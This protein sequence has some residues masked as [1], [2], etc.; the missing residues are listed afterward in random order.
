MTTQRI[1]WAATLLIAL[2]Q[3]W[4]S[5]FSMDSDGIA[6]LEVARTLE[7]NAY[8]SPLFSW[9]LVPIVRWVPLAWSA[10]AVHA[11]QA[12]FAISAV[13]LADKLWRQ[14]A[15]ETADNRGW[16]LTRW[17]AAWWMAF[18]LTGVHLTQPDTLALCLYL[19]ACV[20]LLQN[21]PVRLGLTLAAAYLTKA[22]LLPFAAVLLGVWSLRHRRQALLAGAVLVLGCAPWWIA[23]RQHT[24]RWTIG[25][26]GPL[27]HAWEVNGVTRWIHGQGGPRS[28][29]QVSAAP[30]AFVYPGTFDT[31]YPPW[32]EPSYWFTGLERSPF[33]WANQLRALR[34]NSL[35]VLWYWLATP[36]FMALL[37]LGARVRD[38]PALG[39]EL[40]SR[41]PLAVPALATTGMH[42]AV[43]FETRYLAAQLFLLGTFPLHAAYRRTGPA[44]RWL[45]PTAAAAALLYTLAPPLS[46]SARSLL[47]AGNTPNPFA[48][49]AA[50]LHAAGAT[51]GTPVA[52][53][54]LTLRPEWARQAGLRIVGDIPMTFE[55]DPGPLRRL[56]C[57]TANLDGFWSAPPS[58]RQQIYRAFARAGARFVVTHDVPAH[59]DTAAWTRLPVEVDLFTGPGPL[60]I[61][62][63]N[64][65]EDLPATSVLDSAGPAPAAARGSAAPK[66][67][68]GPG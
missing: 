6:Y 7:V 25:D 56:Y 30:D 16:M 57:N 27:N 44:A 1:L 9:L 21:R 4:Y 14:L 65:P 26:S 36:G 40:R 62:R 31:V 29:R 34:E 47:L 10:A 53:I 41:W 61:R 5:R 24:G 28:T 35:P 67:R 42:A 33:S 54:G 38:W 20:L 39:A 59:A 52:F 17:M 55:R 46:D 11:L 23:L 60:W 2:L 48:V 12:V 66:N 3:F 50:E 45:F 37:A 63:L 68:P 15:P 49:A 22:A 43:F 58:T 64:L 18:G 8:W 32:Y 13:L 19:A 51:P